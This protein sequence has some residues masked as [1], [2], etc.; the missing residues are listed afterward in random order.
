MVQVIDR[1]DK[2]VWQLDDSGESSNNLSSIFF[3][4]EL[5]WRI[6]IEDAIS[7]VVF[8]KCE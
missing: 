2:T 1:L 3:D 4:Y 6:K 7:S 8:K 5:F